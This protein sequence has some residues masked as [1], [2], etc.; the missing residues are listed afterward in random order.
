MKTKP[1]PLF[2]FINRVG[3]DIIKNNV[4]SLFEPPITIAS[5]EHAKALH[6]AQD[7]GNRYK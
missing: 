1:K 4:L 6:A 7:K 5:K 2:W 3:K